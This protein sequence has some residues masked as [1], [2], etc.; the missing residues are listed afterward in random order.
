MMSVSMMDDHK[1]D[2]PLREARGIGTGIGYSILVWLIIAP[3]AWLLVGVI[4]AAL[5]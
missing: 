1:A 2:D 5:T 3:L 4:R